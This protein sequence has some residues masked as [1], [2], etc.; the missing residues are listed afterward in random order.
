MT[1]RKTSPTVFCKALIQRELEALKAEDI[2]RTCWPIMQRLIERADELS[3]V[4]K[5]IIDKYGYADRSESYCSK[6]N[7]VLLILEHIWSS[8]ENTKGT[9]REAKDNLQLFL[10]TRERI[11]VLS[12]QLSEALYELDENFENT[13]LCRDDFQSSHGVL[14]QAGE[15]NGRFRS[16]LL[17]KIKPLTCQFDLRYW[18]TR[19]ELVRAIGD[20]ESGQPD[21]THIEFPEEVITGRSADIK[22]F[23]LAF[24]EGFT[25]PNDLPDKFRFSNSAMAE[26]MNIVQNRA[27]DDL[28]TGDAIKTV[29]SRYQ[30]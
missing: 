15:C 23:V 19:A 1:L 28:V 2:W 9:V 6:G 20:F 21:P 30:K 11:K 14:M 8:S 18:P 26:I 12:A 17:P 7:H 13:G 25:E 27:P 24:D 4:F 16:Y 10:E 29:R 22:N 5:E 3:I